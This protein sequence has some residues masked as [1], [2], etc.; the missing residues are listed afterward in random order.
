M[1]SGIV[2]ADIRAGVGEVGD[3]GLL[4]RHLGPLEC[5]CALGAGRRAATPAWTARDQFGPEPAVGIGEFV[6]ASAG[7]SL[8]CAGQHF[9]QG[10]VPLHR[11]LHRERAAEER[12]TFTEPT[13]VCGHCSVGFHVR[14]KLWTLGMASLEPARWRHLRRPNVVMATRPFSL[15]CAKRLDSG[16]KESDC[17]R[18]MALFKVLLG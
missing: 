14:S 5:S 9:D 10:G 4:G 18:D 15:Q 17:L 1:Q 7:R 3:D 8:P 12:R 6:V 2:D 16:L 13:L 11:L